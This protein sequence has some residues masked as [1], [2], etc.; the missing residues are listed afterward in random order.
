MSLIQNFTKAVPMI[1]LIPGP[2]TTRAEVRAAMARD[3]APWND[4]FRVISRRI[5]HRVREIAGGDEA[6]HTALPLQGCG[7]FGTEAAL[8]STLPV[9]GRVLVPLTGTYAE[10][11]VRLAREAG[12]VPVTLAV[13]Q[14]RPLPPEEVAAALA[15][16]PEISHVGLVYSETSTGVIHDAVAIGAAVRAAGRRMVL[17][18]VSAFGALPLNMSEQTEIDAAIFTTNK[19]LE[20]LPGM[21][22]VVVRNDRLLAPGEAGSWSFDLADIL[23]LSRRDGGGGFRF[24]PAAQ[25][26]AA[27][28]A[29]LDFYDQEGGQKARLA[30]YQENARIVW[31][32]MARIGLRPCL[33]AADQ[34]PIVVNIHAPPDPAWSLPGFVDGLMAHGFTISNFYNTEAPSFRVGCIGHVTPQDMQRFVDAVDAVVDTL[35]VKIRAG[36]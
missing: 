14:N 33:E 3:F 26:V 27:F 20:G 19:C 11:M 17:D 36:N 29:A 18:A 7:H 8:R 12:R 13:D 9:G 15:A 22:F 30:R 1:L 23:T 16:D 6:V 10:R 25:T 34:G 2:V 4:E 32:G 31:Q 35:G 5:R 21:A 24:T 28:D